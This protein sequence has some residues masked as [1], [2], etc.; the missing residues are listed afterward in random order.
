MNVPVNLARMV[1][2]VLMVSMDIIVHVPM[3][4]LEQTVNKV[5]II[6]FNIKCS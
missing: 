4:M 1:V 6:T 5:G 2:N 3:D